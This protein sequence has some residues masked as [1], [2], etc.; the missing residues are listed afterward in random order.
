[1]CFLGLTINCYALSYTEPP[2]LAFT[3]IGDLD[4]GTN[5]VSGSMLWNSWDPSQDS[6]PFYFNIDSGSILNSITLN[7]ETYYDD[8]DADG[9][10]FAGIRWSLYGYDPAVYLLAEVG[11]GSGNGNIYG[12]GT[13]LLF[14]SL[15]LG[16]GKY[17]L[18]PTVAVRVG[19]SW[20]T[21]YSMSLQVDPAASVPEPATVILLGTG[22][23][24]VVGASRK[25]FKK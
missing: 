25:K 4:L 20:D 19:D 17:L 10:F 5:T 9:N 14:S 24:G 21:E 13:S 2:D 15:N 12:D 3:N 22:L 6:D 11:E 18:Y 23:I 16:A 1:M 8:H 7:Y